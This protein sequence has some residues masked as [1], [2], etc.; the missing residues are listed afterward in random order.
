LCDP[1]IGQL[2][3][4]FGEQAGDPLWSTSTRLPA[5]IVRYDEP[6]RLKPRHVSLTARHTLD[7]ISRTHRRTR[8]GA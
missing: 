8:H 7:A 6:D 4:A 5:Q 2:G 1:A 3:F